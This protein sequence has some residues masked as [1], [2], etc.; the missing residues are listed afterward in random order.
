MKKT[1]FLF[2]AIITLAFQLVSAQKEAKPAKEVFDLYFNSWV[3][4]DVTAQKALND[5]QRPTVEGQDMYQFDPSLMSENDNAMVD[6][7]LS[8]FSK[9][10]ASANKAET[11][12]YFDAMLHN[13][14]NPVYKL[15]SVKMVDNEYVENQ[16]IAHYVYDVTFKVPE[17]LNDEEKKQ[18]DFKNLKT[19]KPELLKKLL[20][21]MTDKLK[22]ASRTITTEQ[23]FDLY[24]GEQDGKTYYYN[25]DPSTLV[26]NLTDFYFD[27]VN[28]SGQQ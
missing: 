21:T 7:F 24:A 14:R 26:M 18:F 20:V 10:T 13:F 2:V 16:K 3:K 6:N 4:N 12:A 8:M 5:Y 23:E 9:A 19:V 17:Q 27:N 25:G 1:R 28:I 15:K 11:K 22:N